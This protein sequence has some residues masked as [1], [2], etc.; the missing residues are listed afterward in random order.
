MVFS[1]V[2]E[3]GTAFGKYIVSLSALLFDRLGDLRLIA[4]GGSVMG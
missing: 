1:L 3:L 4:G 2:E